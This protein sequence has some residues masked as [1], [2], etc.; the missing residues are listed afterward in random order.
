M[1]E[2]LSAARE[3]EA[4]IIGSEKRTDFQERS[5]NKTACELR[6]TNNVQGQYILANFRAKWRL[7]CLLSFKSTSQHAQF[8]N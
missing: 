7:L 6:G 8:E 2:N 3:N 1:L 4:D 5:S